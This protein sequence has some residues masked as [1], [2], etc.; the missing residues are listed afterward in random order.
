MLIHPKQSWWTTL[1]T[2]MGTNATKPEGN[3]GK[4]IS[5]STVEVG[6]INLKSE[7]WNFSH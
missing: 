3:D 6:L 2:T 7:S 1:T 5:E 4:E